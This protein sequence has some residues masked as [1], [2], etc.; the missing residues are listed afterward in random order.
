MLHHGE[1]SPQKHEG[2]VSKISYVSLAKKQQ[3]GRRILFNQQEY[4]SN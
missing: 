1:L 2:E 3:Q 4:D